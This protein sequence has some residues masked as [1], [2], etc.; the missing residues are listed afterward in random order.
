[1]FH[2]LDTKLKLLQEVVDLYNLANDPY[3][4]L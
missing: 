2:A 3:V 1:M 4:C